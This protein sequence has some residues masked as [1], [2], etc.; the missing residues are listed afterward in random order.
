MGGRGSSG[1]TRLMGRTIEQDRTIKK[2]TKQTAKLKNEQYRIID[3]KGEV[4]LKKQGKEHSVASTVGEKRQYL[5][6]NISLHNHP[7]G[8][9]FSG[10]DLTD[11]G[12]GA[13][14]IV[15]V[16]KEGTYRLINNL[17]GFNG[18]WTD[19]R[20]GWEKIKTPEGLELRKQAQANMANS[21]TNRELNAIVNKWND[22]RNSKG[23]E[24]ANQYMD[25][26][27]ERY[28]QLDQKRREEV[29][30]EERRLEVEPYHEYFKKNASK[31]G[32]TYRFEKK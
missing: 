8:G 3:P 18:N 1:R 16:A 21:R 5:D 13:R 17:K 25:S 23:N 11:F 22:I 32:F 2:L 28:N 10:D 31:Y 24:S 15:A 12:Y 14:E 7:N 29:K 4:L 9:T 26:V 19:L 6:G 20:D 30:A 27:R